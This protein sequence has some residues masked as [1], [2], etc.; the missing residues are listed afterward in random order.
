MERGDVHASVAAAVAVPER[1]VMIMPCE[2]P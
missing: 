1:H 2:W